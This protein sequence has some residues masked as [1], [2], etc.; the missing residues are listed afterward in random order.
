MKHFFLAAALALAAFALPA[1]AEPYLTGLTALAV[2]DDQINRKLDGYIWYPT[3][4]QD[5][6]AEHH[7]NKVWQT[8]TAAQDALP[9]AGKFPLIVLSHGMYGNVMNQSWLASELARKGFMVAAINHPGT[10]SWL[11]EPDDARQLWER[12]RDVT[13]VIDHVLNTADLAQYIDA[14]RIYMGGH[15]L[16]G[17]TAI[18][19]AGGR[20][21][22]AQF[23]GFCADH[24]GELV[25]GILDEWNVGKTP[26]DIAL[27]SAD[28]KEPRI[29]RFALFDLGGTQTFSTDSLGQIATPML[30]FGAPRDVHGLDLDIE[31]RALVAAL[32]ADITTYLE[33]ET[34]TH[35]DFMGECTPNGL[36]VLKEVEPNDVFVCIDG[37]TERRAK[38]EMIASTV[39]AFFSQD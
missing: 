10:S 11:R 36:E 31:S 22:A 28:L 35:F 24:P 37:T 8:I 20:Y 2:K 29:K 17:F 12:P 33:P 23:N 4:Q 19:L 14:S 6:Q 27:M 26:E 7:G 15:S 18:A 32:P 39:A 9:A 30:V 16:G 5:G 38:H 34:L 3:K 13:R 1:T 21:D 25:C